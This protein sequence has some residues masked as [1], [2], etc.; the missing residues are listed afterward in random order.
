MLLSLL[1]QFA[2]IASEIIE[3][4]QTAE[5]NLV[6]IMH[7]FGTS[8]TSTAMAMEQTWP[9]VTVPDFHRRAMASQDVS[10]GR[11]LALTIAVD[12]TDEARAS[13]NQYSNE[14]IGWYNESHKLAG[15]T[16][17]PIIPFMMSLN[18]AWGGEEDTENPAA[19]PSYGTQ[20]HLVDWQV[21]P[22]PTNNPL[23]I[24]VD[25]R[26]EFTERWNY[27]NETGRTARSPIVDLNSW[28]EEPTT[29][30]INLYYQ[31]VFSDFSETKSLVAMVHMALNWHDHFE[32]LLHDE[33]EGIMVVL[34]STC[35]DLMTLQIDGSTVTNLGDG[36]LH[37]REFEYLGQTAGLTLALNEILEGSA[38]SEKGISCGYSLTVYPSSKFQ[39]SYT[40]MKPL[41]YML[42]VLG[43][44]AFTSLVFIL[45]DLL[46]QKRQETVMDSAVKTND[47]VDSLFPDQFRQQML[48]N[49]GAHA[50]GKKSQKD[51]F[52]A[53]SVRKSLNKFVEG[54]EFE[55]DEAKLFL[56][57]PVADLFPAAT[58][59]M[60]DICG[61]TAW[62]SVREP[63]QVFTLL[64]SIY[65]A[66]DK[67]AERRKVFKVETVS[68]SYVCVAGVP[69]PMAQHA[70]AMAR[71]ARD[72]AYK[73]P[74]IVHK[75]ERFLGPGTGDITMRFGLHSGPVT[76]GVLRG[77]KARFQLFGDTGKTRIPRD[78]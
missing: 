20:L 49:A 72:C 5:N 34:K 6:K 59:M 45:Y 50:N 74:Q 14:N 68:D 42:V 10:G 67:I 19:I 30:P 3:V 51:A 54:G 29:D 25:W 75:L 53:P 55:D 21:A 70:T 9:N 60:A 17:G 31:P 66:F 2:G 1:L 7:D 69:T 39:E 41:G 71:F 57:K 16:P 52:H 24:R 36:D 12:A 28:L 37:D 47:I 18:S 15:T 63:T 33:T 23:L 58:V 35:G 44:F 11:F 27:M 4:S 13:W 77:A 73:L 62:S 40:T 48:D 46:V 78:I 43:I 76:A 38:E 26:H 56:S 61:F 64:E 8:I 65:S 22:P 32:N